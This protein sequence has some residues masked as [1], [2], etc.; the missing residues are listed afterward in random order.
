MLDLKSA[1]PTKT[2][3]EAIKGHPRNGII[4]FK[5]WH[6]NIKKKSTETSDGTGCYIQAQ[7]NNLEERSKKANEQVYSTQLVGCEQ[8]QGPHYT[9]ELPTKRKKGKP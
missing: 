8:C 1:V 4:I 6:M 5:K 7:L 3:A 2:A 9:K